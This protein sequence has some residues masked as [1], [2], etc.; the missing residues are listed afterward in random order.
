MTKLLLVEDDVLLGQGV[1]DFLSQQ[2]YQCIWVKTLRDVE[3][4]WFQSDLVI[5][6]RQM[7]DGDS[8]NLLP[9]WLMKKALPVIFLTARIE[10]DDRVDGLEAGSS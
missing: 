5:L 2:G 6:D 3:Q 8:L 1:V 7:P 10:V 4:Y 9:V